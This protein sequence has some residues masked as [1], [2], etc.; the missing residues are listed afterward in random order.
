MTW[1]VDDFRQPAHCPLTGTPGNRSGEALT[2]LVA[3]FHVDTAERYRRRD[4]TGDDKAETFCNVFVSDVTRALGC[5]VPHLLANQQLAWL[6]RQRDW[7]AVEEREAAERALC[8]CPVVAGWAN[9]TASLPGHVALVVPPPFERAGLWV[10][11]AGA[12]CSPRT[13]MGLAF[14]S[15]PVTFFTHN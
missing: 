11:Q 3:L 1:L 6:A 13:T 2:A 14:G 4:V 5:P 15:R 10:A 8:G 9:P 12:F 7:W